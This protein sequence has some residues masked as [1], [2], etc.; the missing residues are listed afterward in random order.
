MAQST[1]RGVAIGGCI[2]RRT[3]FCSHRI[4]TIHFIQSI[5]I[6]PA[7]YLMAQRHIGVLVTLT[8]TKYSM[9]SYGVV[10]LNLFRCSWM[11]SAILHAFSLYAIS[12]TL[13]R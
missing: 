9:G 6:C 13:N 11:I 2:K 5:Y 3:K 10:V 12:P 1:S 4:S 8:S 7:F